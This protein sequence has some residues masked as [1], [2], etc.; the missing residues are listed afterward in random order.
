[1]QIYYENQQAEKKKENKMYSL[2]IKSTLR[3]LM[4][5]TW[6]VLKEMGEK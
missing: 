1:M 2:G 3:I 6:F 5:E 4:L